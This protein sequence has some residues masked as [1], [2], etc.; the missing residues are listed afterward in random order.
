MISDRA[1]PAQKDKL[2][3]VHR[4][5]Q[6]PI[7]GPLA[8]GILIE[9]RAGSENEWRSRSLILVKLLFSVAF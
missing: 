6:F 8:L 7:C 5:C 4:H 3:C 9:L 2:P 1:G